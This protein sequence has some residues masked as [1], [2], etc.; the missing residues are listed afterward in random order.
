MIEAKEKLKINLCVISEGK[1]GKST[2]QVSNIDLAKIYARITGEKAHVKIHLQKSVVEV[3]KFELQSL[4]PKFWVL[5]SDLPA[6]AE[7]KV[8]NSLVVFQERSLK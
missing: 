1:L 8:A 5:G 7:A 4:G 6:A 2:L 3:I